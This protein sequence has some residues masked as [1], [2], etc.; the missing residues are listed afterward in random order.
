MQV[1]YYS[2]KGFKRKCKYICNIKKQ[3]FISRNG[4]LF[5]QKFKDELSTRKQV[6]GRRLLQ[7]Y[8]DEKPC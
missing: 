4:K 3:S 5:G 6:N 2:L 1:R 8:D 7:T